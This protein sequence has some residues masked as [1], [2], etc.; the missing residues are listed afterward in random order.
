MRFKLNLIAII[1]FFSLFTDFQYAEAKTK[2]KC[3]LIHSY[4]EGS[5]T[6]GSSNGVKNAFKAKGLNVSIQEK[7]YD[8]YAYLKLT[9]LEKK[10][11]NQN[12]VKEVVGFKPDLIIVFDDEATD[13]L[14]NELNKL[15]IPIVL[16][17]INKEKSDLSWWLPN[18]HKERYFTGIFERYPFE[19]SVKLL[20][21]IN[22]KIKKLSILT[23]AN[24][25]AKTVTGQLEGFFNKNN[26]EY[27]GIRLEHTFMSS[28][29][30]SWQES[31][32]NYKGN[33]KAFWIVSPWDVRDE[34]GLEVSL[35]V[36]A[37]YY[38]KHSKL[39]NLAIVSVNQQLGFLASFAVSPEDLGYQAAEIGF[40]ILL[41]GTNPRSIKFEENKVIRFVINK[42]RS[43]ELGYKLP[44]ELLEFA[45]IEKKIPMNFVR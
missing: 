40:K 6:V 30:S 22:P 36:I 34:N 21:K 7:I 38:H 13:S 43:D 42:K 9:E 41:S 5:W 8:Y 28:D 12:I 33:D 25:S 17:G 10:E 37:N 19:Q 27:L 20:H 29:W 16:S 11:K 15:K 31:I 32:K 1:C 2:F 3:F 24:E 35:S 18:N 23:G 44:I 4:Q 26:N 14:I 45:K 39:P